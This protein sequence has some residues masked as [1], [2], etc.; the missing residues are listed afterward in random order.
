MVMI[1]FLP[2]VIRFFTRMEPLQEDYKMKLDSISRQI[3][4]QLIFDTDQSSVETFTL[5]LFNPNDV[6][7]KDLKGFGLSSEVSNRW[8][9]YLDAGG[10]FR[11]VEDVIKIY[12]LSDEDFIRLKP[13][14]LIP[15]ISETTK[16]SPIGK[17]IDIEQSE[18]YKKSENSRKSV[19]SFNINE[20]DSTEL[21]KIRGI[22]KILS[23]RIVRFRSNLGGFVSVDQLDEVYGIEDYALINLKEAALME[24]DF[25]PERKNINKLDIEEL[26]KHPYVGYQEAKVIVAYRSQHGEFG[27]IHD[28]LQIRTLDSTWLNRVYPYL[29]ITNQ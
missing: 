19:L 28:L 27:A 20:V 18:N 5:I 9:K 7:Y 24:E 25:T 21:Q 12:G 13:F 3:N 29:S 23:S 6:T 15:R 4:S 10:S 2:P 8:L 16:R 26:A 22:G 14:I 17:R 11:K 1:T